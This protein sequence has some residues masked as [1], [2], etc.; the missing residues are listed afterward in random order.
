MPKSR[1]ADKIK[2]VYRACREGTLRALL[3]D[4]C[5]YLRGRLWFRA[6]R[7][8]HVID[9]WIAGIRFEHNLYLPWTKSRGLRYFKQEL[10]WIDPDRVNFHDPERSFAGM[11]FV[12]DGDW[13]FK[14]A[15]LDDKLQMKIVKAIFVDGLEITRMEEFPGLVEKKLQQ[16]P[17]STSQEAENRVIE[18]HERLKRV[19]TDI[20]KCGYKT[21]E[22]LGSSP[23]NRF[24]TWYDEIRISIGRDGEYILSGSGNH[25]LAIAKVLKLKAVPALIIRKHYKFEQNGGR[26]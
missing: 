10:T 19:F 25:R 3:A 4:E 26:V 24:N 7:W 23:K 1:L 6:P 17:G 16:F 18:D 12:Q 11:Y 22:E 5:R 8:V 14:K 21:Q 20:Q 9:Y 2:K 15:P 13:D